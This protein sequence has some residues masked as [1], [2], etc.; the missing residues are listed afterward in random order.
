M[1]VILS[2]STSSA[3]DPDIYSFAMAPQGERFSVIGKIG[4]FILIDNLSFERV[5]FPTIPKQHVRLEAA[6]LSSESQWLALGA[7]DGSV[8]LYEVSKLWDA[9][10]KSWEKPP[11]FILNEHQDE[12]WAIAFSPDGERI[13]SG[14]ADGKLK[15]SYITTSTPR[16]QTSIFLT[17]ES[18]SAVKVITFSPD[19]KALAVGR[20]DGT[21]A[22]WD[23]ETR[24]VIKRYEGHNWEVTA[25]AFS[26]NSNILASGTAFSELV[27]WDVSRYNELTSLEG[28]DGNIGAINTLAFS[29]DGT[30][31]ASGGADNQVLL[32]STESGG[33][34]KEFQSKNSVLSVVFTADGRK[35]VVGDTVGTVKH[36]STGMYLAN[37][38]SKSSSNPIT[39]A[40]EQQKVVRERADTSQ[41]ASQ[42]KPNN[43]EKKKESK[44]ITFD[45]SDETPPRITILRAKAVEGKED[46]A[47]ISGTVK[48][49]MNDIRS[50]K[51][52]GIP[53]Q[54]SSTNSFR[55]TLPLEEGTT[56]FT[57]VA[58]DEADNSA[59]EDIRLYRKLEPPK[60][61]VISPQLD[62]N[63]YAE[64]QQDQ[65]EIRVK[66]TDDSE[67]AEVKCNS[68]PMRYRSS[69]N[70]SAIYSLSF[71]YYQ[72]GPVTFII[73]AKDTK[74]TAEARR[75]ITISSVTDKTPPIIEILEKERQVEAHRTEAYIS[76]RIRDTESGIHSVKIGNAE[77]FLDSKGGFQHRVSL[78]EG[79]NTFTIIAT[80]MDKND[81]GET[82]TI[83]R[84]RTAPQITVVNPT[85]NLNNSAKISGDSFTVTVEVT[86]ESQIEVR[87]NGMKVS[88][89][90]DGKTFSTTLDRSNVPETVTIVATDAA[91]KSS[92]KS[93]AVDF[94]EP[95][96]SVEKT[97]PVG[98]LDEPTILTDT[99]DPPKANQPRTS[100]AS[101][102][103]EEDDP[104]ITFDDPDL[105]LGR[106]HETR[107]T[108]FLLRTYIIDASEI[109]VRVERKVRGRYEHIKDV[110]R[111][112][113]RIYAVNLPLRQGLNEFRIIAEDEWSNIESK[114]FTI[115]K[116]QIDN[117]G[118]TIQ[119]FRVGDQRTYSVG[120]SIAAGTSIAVKQRDVRIQGR[121][122]DAS[123][124][125]SVRITGVPITVDEDGY[126]EKD[127]PLN[128]GPN[129]ITVYATDTQRYSSEFSL[130][131]TRWYDRTGKDFALLFATDKYVGKK[132]EDGNWK[133]LTGAIKDAEAVAKKLRENYGFETRIFENLP[134]VEL[135]K[136]LFEYRKD[137][138]G[139]KY[140]PDSQ[141][142]L[143]F[144]GHGYFHDPDPEDDE[145]GEGYLITADTY[146]FVED[147]WMNTALKHEE[148]RKVIDG[149]ACQHILVLLDTCFSGTFDPTYE[150]PRFPLFKGPIDGNQLEQIKKA[151][152]V[153]ARWC[154]TAAGAEFVLDGNNGQY[155]PFALAFLNAL[156]T[157]GGDD[158]LLTL[159]EVWERVEESK[160]N[161]VYDKA[162]KQLKEKEG[163]DLQRPEPR[164]GQ[165]GESDPESDFLFFP[166]K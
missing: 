102:Q 111:E 22:L 162:I 89:A 103:K 76:G 60:I 136:K 34:L 83:Y 65:V 54:L 35:L 113:Q 16:R 77:V 95:Q 82:V 26:P 123:G 52:N 44:I 47:V 122:I 131:I 154:L 66:V 25:L 71:L 129:S 158:S 116:H 153:K 105:D 79:N 87:I 98:K 78:K 36:M 127:I 101:N 55:E 155:S 42:V 92:S 6:A 141:L 70:G 1:A 125:E 40:K 67:I 88:A 96:Q 146:S 12:I 149:I 121:V 132:D 18:R 145:E 37:P 133:D 68:R 15:L 128:Y 150:K 27:L 4:V 112:E 114:M 64:I 161:P 72:P 19:G 91:G 41:S 49:E 13:A 110:P 57:I 100:T 94:Q 29:S 165:F 130:T 107:E 50:V 56:I 45:E 119:I 9:R 46:T 84:K 63:N 74:G 73:T 138:E 115:V 75:K 135:T 118:P 21:V 31:L 20:M 163:K 151:L 53:I 147:P 97:T 108:S 140:A 109:Q 3:D 43:I 156:E 104:K 2:V 81:V 30:V 5:Q 134:K 120:T 7:S 14:G 137:F 48:D 17:S 23:I 93:F 152:E 106:N 58:V 24:H 61:E 142:L 160:N 86:D 90:V 80:D 62:A 10:K 59:S 157:K 33:K 124:I 159:E 28:H 99:F 38:L 139:I 148:L 143:F 39:V 11:N 166:V 144:S 8:L 51:I 164:R 32:W 69:V 85:L 126:F 117:V